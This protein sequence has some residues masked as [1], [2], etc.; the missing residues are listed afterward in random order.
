[1]PLCMH[2]L[3]SLTIGVIPGCGGTQR[4]I[5]AVG[6]AK[7]MDMVLT[8]VMID[9][10]EAKSSGLVSRIFPANELVEGALKMADEISSFSK[11]VVSAFM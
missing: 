3:P 4:L 2:T 7:A 11:P 1:M 10:E 6:K 8:G 5:R 9:A